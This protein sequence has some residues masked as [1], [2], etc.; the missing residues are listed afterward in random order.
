MKRY[1]HWLRPPKS[2]PWPG[3]VLCIDVG[4]SW[5][6]H[7]DDA[8]RE[9]IHL[10]QWR[11][12][13]CVRQGDG[14]LIARNAVGN[15]PESF[16]RTLKTATLRCSNLWV[17]CSHTREAAAALGLWER[18]EGGNVRLEGLDARNDHYGRRRLPNVR[19]A[20]T[21]NMGEEEASMG[22]NGV[23]SVSS[24]VPAAIRHDS[25]RHSANRAGTGGICVLQDP[26]IIL[27]LRISGGGSKITWVDAANYGIEP[28]GLDKSSTVGAGTLAV[29]FQSAAS[30]LHSLGRCGWC[31]TAGS[32]AMRLFRSAYHRTP[33]LSHTDRHATALE[34]GGLFGGRCEVYQY[35]RIAGPVH[36]YDI[37]SM[38]PYLCATVPT[39]ISLAYVHKDITVDRLVQECESGYCGVAR[40]DIETEE[41]DY[42]YRLSA[43]EE[44][45]V[46]KQ[47]VTSR[48]AIPYGERVIYPV[49]RYT[50]VLAGD[51]LLHAMQ[52]GRVR[53][54]R[55]AAMYHCS[56]ALEEY[57]R[58]LYELR[59]RS[60][61][62][63]DGMLSAYIKRLAV[64]LPGKFAQQYCK[65]VD[66]PN[67]ELPT[68]WGEYYWISPANELVRYRSISGHVQVEEK[69]GFSYGAVPSISVAICAAGRSRL[70]QCIL[71]A[72]KHNTHYCDTDAVIV[73][74]DG[75]DA[76]AE[77]RWIRQ[78]EW[79]YLQ[80][81]VSAD[82]C[83]IYGAKRYRI[84]G[85]IRYAG[86]IS[87]TGC[88]IKSKG[89]DI[90]LPPIGATIRAR[91]RPASW[92]PAPT[93]E[94]GGHVLG[95][96]HSQGG[97]VQPIR[98]NRWDDEQSP[99][100]GPCPF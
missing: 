60:D 63:C 21:G 56:N 82:W 30:T 18:M 15:D 1:E 19:G 36:L 93:G 68:M 57:Q 4:V 85:R 73:S 44:I 92:K 81:V 38:Y 41:P 39:P 16:W 75:R 48:K 28:C 3:A 54:V 71:A 5:T 2:S 97:R 29:W 47:A 8:R 61:N 32:Q 37:R 55:L 96:A 11:A 78:G 23:R 65:W 51:E 24:G 43:W 86:K 17:I 13:L 83:E 14:Y 80:H 12:T 87:E 62:R 50:T 89:I 46:N 10:E 69:G 6:S 45:N 40:V 99:T 58:A 70:R 95:D 35:G 91:Q 33:I 67:A 72:G 9:Y 59:C 76:L 20:R 64:S 22:T 27:E 31:H 7:H 79:G 42:P 25:G 84:G 88:D 49:G 53:R 74:N 52:S 100:A 66:L 26:P 94:Y 90:T 34:R 98:I 77:A